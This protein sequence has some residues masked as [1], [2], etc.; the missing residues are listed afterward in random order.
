MGR[1]REASSHYSEVSRGEG[2][3]FLR[4]DYHPPSGG[5]ND[6]TPLRLM[7]IL[8]ATEYTCNGESNPPRDTRVI[9]SYY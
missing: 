8:L 4:D 5:V 3:V 7:Q 2:G 6:N 9:Y 1:I